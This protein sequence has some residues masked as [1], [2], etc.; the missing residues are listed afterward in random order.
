QD[1]RL[2][3]GE[4]YVGDRRVDLAAITMPVLNIYAEKD[5]LVSPASSLALE[6]HIGSDDYQVL[7]YPV[8]HIGLYVSGNVQADLPRRIPDWPSRSSTP[9]ATPGSTSSACPSAEA[10]PRRWPTVIRSASAPSSWPPPAAA[11]AE[12]LGISS[13]S[14]SWLPRSASTRPRTT[15]RSPRSCSAGRRGAVPSP[16]TT[17]SRPARHGRPACGGISVSSWPWPAG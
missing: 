1:N 5:D 6:R 13:P 14:S 3:K 17:T 9:W 11:G 8:G 15:G 16:S 10:W 12:C 7:S 2:V 4:L